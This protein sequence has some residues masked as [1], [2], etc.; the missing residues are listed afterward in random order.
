MKTKWML[1]GLIAVALGVAAFGTTGCSKSEH[2]HASGEQM[3][4]AGT[5]PVVIA[6][7]TASLMGDTNTGQAMPAVNTN[8][9]AS[10]VK[11]ALMVQYTCSM[12]PEVV[13]DKPGRCP[14]CSMKLIEKK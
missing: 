8:Q 9:A 14:K 2:E 11:A 5:S 10:E 3:H 4:D 12:H 1:T 6:S 7:N 13:Q